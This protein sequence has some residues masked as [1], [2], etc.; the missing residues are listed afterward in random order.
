MKNELQPNHEI[1]S[2]K[3]IQNNPNYNNVN[4]TNIKNIS[5]NQKLK[6]LS[7]IYKKQLEFNHKLDKIIK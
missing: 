1:I 6:H 5:D 3:I 7:N 2:D 4:N